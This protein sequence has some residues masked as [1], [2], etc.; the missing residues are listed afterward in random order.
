M[1][2]NE[3]AKFQRFGSFFF[4]LLLGLGVVLPLGIALIFC[5]AHGTFRPDVLLPLTL[6]IMFMVWIILI[7][8][9][10]YGSLTSLFVKK[11][12]KKVKDLPYHF[13]SSFKGRGGILYID[14]ENGMIGFISAYN[15]LKV[16]VFNAAR[17]ESARTIASAMTGIRFVFYLDGKK[18]SMPTL[19]T[20]K[21]VSTKSG[22]GAEAVSKA[23]TFV[24][25]L[26]AAR[27]TARSLSGGKN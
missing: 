19:L 22:I 17:I 1:K 14:V 26:L 24:E 8:M 13:N 3:T 15:P 9:I 27:T 6:V 20:N 25:L 16:Q 21:I 7:M 23:D 5:A 11:T 10:G 18:I 2:E 12:A 4:L